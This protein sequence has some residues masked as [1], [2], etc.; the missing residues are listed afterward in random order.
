MSEN[1]LSEQQINK[2]LSMSSFA[3]LLAIYALKLSLDKKISFNREDFAKEAYLTSSDYFFGFIVAS[4]AIGLVSH[5][6]KNGVITVTAIDPIISSKIEKIL[7]ENIKL[8]TTR[9]ADL[10]KVKEYFV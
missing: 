1:N 9:K 4:T 5:N 6:I 8:N 3:G 2:F 10:N 7:E